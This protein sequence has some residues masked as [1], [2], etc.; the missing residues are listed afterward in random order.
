MK[1]KNGYT[2]IAHIVLRITGISLLFIAMVFGNRK[3]PKLVES[4]IRAGK[5]VEL[6]AHFFLDIFITFVQY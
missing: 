4:C 2:T 6:P 3:V 1:K 5:C